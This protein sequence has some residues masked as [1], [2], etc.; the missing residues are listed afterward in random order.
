MLRDDLKIIINK[1]DI[2]FTGDGKANHYFLLMVCGLKPK[3]AY[4][5]AYKE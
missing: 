1:V 3:E 2:T 5:I 4:S